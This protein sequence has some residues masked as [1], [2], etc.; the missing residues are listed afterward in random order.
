LLQGETLSVTATVYAA[1]IIALISV[2]QIFAGVYGVR[3]WGEPNRAFSVAVTAG[4]LALVEGAVII[5]VFVLFIQQTLFSME[6][7]FFDLPLLPLVLVFVGSIAVFTY[8]RTAFS[9]VLQTRK[10]ALEAV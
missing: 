5:G 7:I 3:R 10:T 6:T 2:W 4:I 8:A 1:L 9:Y